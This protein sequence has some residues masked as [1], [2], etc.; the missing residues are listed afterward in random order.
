MPLQDVDRVNEWR[1][2]LGLSPLA[3]YMEYFGEEWSEEIYKKELPQCE[4]AFRNWY[5][6]RK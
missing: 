4:E 1:K 6:E 2:E 3:E 5:T